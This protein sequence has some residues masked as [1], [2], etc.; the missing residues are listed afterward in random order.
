[1]HCC[2]WNQ[3]D[4]NLIHSIEITFLIDLDNLDQLKQTAR[5]GSMRPKVEIHQNTV[6]MGLQSK[7]NNLK[8]SIIYF[9]IS[10]CS[11]M[12][13]RYQN[14][15]VGLACFCQGPMVK[16]SLFDSAC[17]AA[18]S[19]Y[20]WYTV[21]WQRVRDAPRKRAR[22]SRQGNVPAGNRARDWWQKNVRTWIGSKK[23]R[24]LICR[25]VKDTRNNMKVKWGPS[26]LWAVCLIHSFC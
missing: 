3:S 24:F 12:Y 2:W 5:T 14:M 16:T 10:Q 26:C 22:K 9:P 13:S 20:Q 19:W 11:R 15:F 8:M 7:P 4:Q 25:R 1:M 21:P 6:S 17:H 23:V 18:C